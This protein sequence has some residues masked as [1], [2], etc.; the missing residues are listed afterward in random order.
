MA[1]GEKEDFIQSDAQ[2]GLWGGFECR[3]FSLM[4]MRM[5]TKIPCSDSRDW[6][7]DMPPF[8][9]NICSDD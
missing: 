7:G 6:N 9:E 5:G 2:S 1:N 8:S 4:G 3:D